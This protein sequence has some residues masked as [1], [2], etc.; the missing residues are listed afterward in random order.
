MQ[1][2]SLSTVTNSNL[3]AK[4]YCLRLSI[5]LLQA[6]EDGNTYLTSPCLVLILLK[7]QENENY[8]E[9]YPVVLFQGNVIGSLLILEILYGHRIDF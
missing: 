8:A 6:R 2:A 9:K 5:C 4:R 1:Q 3:S 7:E